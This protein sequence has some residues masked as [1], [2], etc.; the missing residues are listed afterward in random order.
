MNFKKLYAWPLAVA[1]VA[2][3]ETKNGAV[4]VKNAAGRT[5]EH[6]KNLSAGKKV[7]KLDIALMGAQAR[8]L[9]EEVNS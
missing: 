5:I 3:T 9:R 7:V 2:A 1:T 4:A 8:A 6:R